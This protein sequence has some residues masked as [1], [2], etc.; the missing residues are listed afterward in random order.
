MSDAIRRES[1][2]KQAVNIA[3]SSNKVRGSEL[4]LLQSA[5][6]LGIGLEDPTRS[7]AEVMAGAKKA[8]G[9]CSP[10]GEVRQQLVT[11]EA[12]KLHLRALADQI[13]QM[14]T[15]YPWHITLIMRAISALLPWYTRPLREFG[16]GCASYFESVAASLNAIARHVEHIETETKQVRQGARWP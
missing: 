12:H 1:I 2:P 6:L 3:V 13:G 11:I 7:A 10:G 9:G 4:K 16:S 15:D 8:A 14:P 5:L